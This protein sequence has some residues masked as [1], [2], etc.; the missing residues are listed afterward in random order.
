MIEI[1]TCAQRT[2]FPAHGSFP[3]AMRAQIFIGRD[4]I[5]NASGGPCRDLAAECG[6][7]PGIDR[8]L[9]EA[10]LRW[11]VSMP[12]GSCMESR[13][14]GSRFIRPTSRRRTAVIARDANRAN[15]SGAR[16]TLSRDPAYR[17]FYRDIGNELPEDY[18]HQVFPN[19]GHR[20]N[21]ASSITGSPGPKTRRSTIADGRWARGLH[22]GDFVRNRSARSNTSAR[23]CRSSRWSQ[24]VRCRVVRP[25]VV[26]G[27][28]F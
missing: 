2:V 7:V 27:R 20:R 1:I 21:T 26:E 25:L 4:T 16:A 22:A 24:P 12:T 10:N 18:L 14:R 3:E 6:Y 5:A 9:Q 8:I 17:D 13:V 15:R 19:I 23:S 28:S 11:F